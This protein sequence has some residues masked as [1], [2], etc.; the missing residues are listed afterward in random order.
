MA[1]AISGEVYAV[2]TK[3]DEKLYG[4]ALRMEDVVALRTLYQLRHVPYTLVVIST[5]ENA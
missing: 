5:H 2:P 4:A 1:A 3:P